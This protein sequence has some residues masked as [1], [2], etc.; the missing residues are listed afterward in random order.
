VAG[1][2][3]VSATENNFTANATGVLVLQGFA[4]SLTLHY[5]NINGNTHA[6]I[7]N[8]STQSVDAEANWWGST[9]GPTSASNPGGTGDKIIGPVDFTNWLTF[10]IST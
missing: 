3:N 4:G 8:D 10:A 6:G 2:V 1:H 7:E 5:N 9:T